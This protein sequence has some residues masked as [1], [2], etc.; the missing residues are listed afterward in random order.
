MSDLI[1]EVPLKFEVERP[2]DIMRE[3]NVDSIQYG[4]QPWTLK[5]WTVECT[6]EKRLR[7]YTFHAVQIA[8][9][10]AHRNIGEIKVFNKGTT[11]EPEYLRRL[12][13]QIDAILGDR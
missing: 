1:G 2:H 7:C 9:L 6:P 5:A 11:F 13:D 4:D 3:L 8:S 12:R 10:E